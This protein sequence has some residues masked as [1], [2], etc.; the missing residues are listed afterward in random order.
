MTGH[1]AE[2]TVPWGVVRAKSLS[3]AT[4]T[5]LCVTIACGPSAQDGARRSEPAEP[6]AGCAGLDLAPPEPGA[7]IQISMETM[8]SPGQE[9]EMCRFFHV[10]GPLAV[11][12]TEGLRTPGSHHGIVHKTS[13]TELPTEDAYGSPWDSREAIPCSRV[14]GGSVGIIAN[15]FAARTYEPTG[16]P[17]A[18]GVL[19]HDVALMVGAGEVLLLVFHMANT[20]DR[21]ERACCKVNLHTIP[22]AQVREEAGLLSWFDPFIP[23]PAAGAASAEFACPITRDVWLASAVS[24]MHSRGVGY[25]ASLIEGDP[26]VL[27]DTLDVLHEF[28]DWREPVPTVFPNAV[29]LTQGQ[30][31]KWRCD[32]ENPEPRDIAQGNQTTDE[33]CQFIGVYWPKSPEMDRCSDDPGFPSLF[34]RPLSRGTRN[35]AE[36]AA[37]FDGKKMRDLFGGGPDTTAARYAA[38]RCVADLCPEVSAHIWDMLSGAVDPSSLG[39]N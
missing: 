39:C 11:N 20:T 37:C 28:T 9:E 31:L 1:R 35:G 4:E 3:F 15:S 21:S 10:D 38:Q 26:L 6:A 5:V 22:E 30:W 23:V 7:G 12:W 29:E 33:M 25:E 14:N 36:F 34:G 16:N 27:P 17:V 13:L 18:K 32:Y 24:H 2:S 8:F 19:P